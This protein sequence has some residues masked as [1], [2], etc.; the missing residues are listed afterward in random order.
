MFDEVKD[1]INLQFCERLGVQGKG[2][3][4]HY[5]SLGSWGRSDGD[6]RI[7]VSPRFVHPAFLHEWP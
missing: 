7:R 5:F 1:P 2:E 4:M 6:V 3:G